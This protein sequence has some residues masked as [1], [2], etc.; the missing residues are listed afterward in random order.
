MRSTEGLT[1]PYLELL[2]LTRYLGYPPF[3]TQEWDLPRLRHVQFDGTLDTNNI[4]ELLDYLLRYASQLETLFLITY[5]PWNDL[6]L[7]FWDTYTALQLLG[8]RY[9][10]LNDR[11]WGGW[12]TTPPRTH[13]F[14]Y[15]VC[16][17]CE[18]DVMTTVDSLR[19]M[20]T[21]HEE[22]ALVIESGIRGDY[23]LIEDIKEDGWESRMT[24]SDGILPDRRKPT[25]VSGSS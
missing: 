1:L 4:H 2:H 21:H 18:E 15:L 8:L 14:R 6:P 24:K 13:P 9:N 19:S 22:V 25:L 17:H 5:Y 20:W 12:T 11:G 16:R 7:G 10:V 3:P 23:Y